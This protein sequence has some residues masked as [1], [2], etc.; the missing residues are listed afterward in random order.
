MIIPAQ[1][2]API[3]TR[4]LMDEVALKGM[5]IPMDGAPPNNLRWIMMMELAG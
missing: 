5:R 3:P 4:T 1:L 2:T